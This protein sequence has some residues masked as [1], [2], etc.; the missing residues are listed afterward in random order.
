MQGPQH[1]DS[2]VSSEVGVNEAITDSEPH[3]SPP[4][5]GPVGVTGVVWQSL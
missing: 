5:S 2:I 1:S 4:P 3:P